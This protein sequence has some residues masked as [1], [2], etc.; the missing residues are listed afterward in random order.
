MK[1]N[2]TL[3]DKIGFRLP[4]QKAWY[5]ANVLMAAT[6]N[7]PA[8][9]VSPA[10]AAVVGKRAIPAY[11]GYSG[12][13]AETA[14]ENTAGYVAGEVFP[15]RPAVIAVPASNG[16]AAVIG[17]PALPPS[18]AY[19]I[20]TAT[21]AIPAI[22]ARPAQ[23]LQ[24]P[25]PAQPAISSPKVEALKGWENAIQIAVTAAKLTITAE[26]PYY[27]GV[28]IIGSDLLV[29]GEITPTALQATAF[30]DPD[31]VYA[32]GQ[33]SECLDQAI[34]TTLEQVFYRMAKLCQCV[35]TDVVK[36][37]N[38]ISTNCKR[39]VVSLYPAPGFQVNSDRFQLD[40][41]RMAANTG[42]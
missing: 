15:G 37:V 16:Y 11:A 19:P 10:V 30:V 33:S 29:I 39:L 22:P 38:G 21:P 26:L 17:I 40:K 12:W 28:G 24:Q 4:S 6:A 9:V 8:I 18:P 25:V 20:G 1:S 32:A 2:P 31:I 7:S 41:I 34:D 27:T 36:N 35:E 14:E 23:L 42:S 3:H 13:I 5:A